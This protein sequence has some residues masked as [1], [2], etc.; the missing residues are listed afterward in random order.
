MKY[1]L[2]TLLIISLITINKIISMDNNLNK[3]GINEQYPTSNNGNTTPPP[4]PKRT[5]PVCPPAPRKETTRTG[6]NEIKPIAAK[7]LIF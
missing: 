3:N 2:T 4:F 7:K 5:T 1:R 6:P